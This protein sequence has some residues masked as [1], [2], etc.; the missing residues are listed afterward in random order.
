[1]LT[2]LTILKGRDTVTTY[3]REQ[4][5]YENWGWMMARGVMAL[6]FGLI[7]L[8]WPGPTLATLV[9][10]FGV[11]LLGDGVTALVYA[12]SGGRTSRG[13]TW[14]L[15]LAGLT[16]IGGAVITFIWPQITVGVLVFIIAFWAIIRGVLEIVAYVDLRRIFGGSW[17]LA[18]SGVLALVFGVVLLAWPSL[19]LRIFAWVVG[20]YAILAGIVF[21]SLAVR[22]RQMIHRR[23]FDPDYTPSDRPSEPTP[24]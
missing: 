21:V 22:M 5:A 7:A 1:M 18:V 19:G 4:V 15:I 2:V 8:V 20:A 14:P 12:A 17:L 16:G 23:E 10:L 11:T 24:A 13:D 3:I 6:L 9:I